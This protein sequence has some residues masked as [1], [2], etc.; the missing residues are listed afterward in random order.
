[1]VK[2]SR[3][4]LFCML[5]ILICLCPLTS[6]GG[7]LPRGFVYVEDTVPGIQIEL[8][9]FSNHNFVG[10]RIDGYMASRCILTKEAAEALKGVQE[11]LNQ[12]GLGL[13]I[14]DAY[15][16]QRAVD[17]FVRWA[18][19]PGGVR[20][21]GEFY[22]EVAKEKL[23]KDGYIVEKSGHSRG[24]TVDLTIVSLDPKAQGVELHMGTCF[25][26][27]GPQSWPNNPEIEAGRRANRMLLRQVMEKHGFNPYLKEWWHFTLQGEPYPAT[28][29]DFPIR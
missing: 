22:P 1:M 26:Y 9:Y 4:P 14:Y 28:Y 13:K 21:K 27:F 8:R 6:F 16:P 17:H 7:Y 29:F 12:F 24:S 11:D 3:L 25:D 19:N 23:F 18:K 20:M 10:E 5:L 2:K 15:R